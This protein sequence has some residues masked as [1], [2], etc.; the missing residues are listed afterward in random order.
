LRARR[1]V[2]LDRFDRRVAGVDV[3][4]GRAVGITVILPLY[5]ALDRYRL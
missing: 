4:S 5:G 1:G 3:D 2:P